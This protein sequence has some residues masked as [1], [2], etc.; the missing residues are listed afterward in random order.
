MKKIIND[1]QNI[2][3]EMIEGIAYS[4]PNDY[5]R[6]GQS[7][8]IQYKKRTKNKVSIVVGGGSG[9]EPMFFGFLGKGLADGVS[10]GNMFTAP[11]PLTIIET[12]KAVDN[13]QGIILLY[14]NHSGDLLNFGM[15]SDLMELEAMKVKSLVVSDDIGSG[16]NQPKKERR[17]VAGIV[18]V[19]KIVGA[20][21]EKGADLATCLEIGKRVNEN[22]YSIG[23]GIHPGINPVTGKPNFEVAED[24]LEFGIGVHGEPGKELIK[25]EGAEALSKRIFNNLT[26]HIHLN[27]NAKLLLLINGLGSFTMLEQLLISRSIVQLFKKEEIEIVDVVIGNYFT[28][29]DMSG[30][31][32]SVLVMDQEMLSL[33]CE[34][35]YSPVVQIGG[36]R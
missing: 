21:A 17:G 11:N 23:V 16:D 8:A 1:P 36:R 4:Y 28:T 13:N 7:N 25:L 15:A 34:A 30:F 24:E 22:L 31:S 12:A 14:G 2:I 32:V 19:I 10:I 18:F 20:A 33:Y 29:N 27:K 26:K 6:I 3:S 35:S 9:H 5:E